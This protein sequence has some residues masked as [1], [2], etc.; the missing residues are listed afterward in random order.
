MSRH[1]S[2]SIHQRLEEDITLL[3]PLLPPL[4]FLRGDFVPHRGDNDDILERIRAANSL[5]H[6][7]AKLRW[8]SYSDITDLT[9]MDEANG[10]RCLFSV[11]THKC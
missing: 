11:S 2:A 3:Q 10:C 4:L 1:G 8:L 9:H 7:E 5:K 6:P